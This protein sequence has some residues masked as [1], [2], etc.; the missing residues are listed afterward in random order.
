MTLKDKTVKI[1]PELYK[2]IN[3]LIE[4]KVKKITYNSAKQ[5]V[6]IAVLKLLKEE[7]KE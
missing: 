5:F 3:L 6:D 2:R 4:D 7:E 1:N